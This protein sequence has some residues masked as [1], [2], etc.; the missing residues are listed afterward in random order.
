MYGSDLRDIAFLQIWARLSA[1]LANNESH[2]GCLSVSFNTEKLWTWH[3]NFTAR[4]SIGTSV[5]T[6]T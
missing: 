1:E 6:A 4:S 2:S 3:V 5:S